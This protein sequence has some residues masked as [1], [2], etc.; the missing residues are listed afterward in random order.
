M[1]N[2]KPKQKLLQWM[3]EYNL[4]FVYWSLYV[5]FTPLAVFCYMALVFSCREDEIVAQIISNTHTHTLGC[6][7]A[8]V[9]GK[10]I[11]GSERRTQE[12]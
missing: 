12:L 1:P 9:R 6:I 8:S 2:N 4:R 11:C 7:L 3:C 10:T 5:F